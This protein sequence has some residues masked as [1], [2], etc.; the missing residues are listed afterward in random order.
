VVGVVAWWL[1]GPRLACS[2]S[3]VWLSSPVWR[4]SFW[5][6]RFVGLAKFSLG[7]VQKTNVFAPAKQ[8]RCG[9]KQ[10]RCGAEHPVS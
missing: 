2:R 10:P 7:V 5:T 6:G 4:K 1:C 3:L 9:A 8:P